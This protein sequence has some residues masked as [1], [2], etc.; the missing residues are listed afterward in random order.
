MDANLR[1]LIAKAEKVSMS[2][3]ALEE[4]RINFAYGNAGEGNEG[5]KEAVIAAATI[6]KDT[7]PKKR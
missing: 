2:P 3:E 1:S 4:Q 7:E 5:T 6:M